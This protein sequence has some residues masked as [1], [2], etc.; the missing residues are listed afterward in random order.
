LLLYITLAP[1]DYTQI[2]FLILQLLFS[3]VLYIW[4]KFPISFT[5]YI[6]YQIC[7]FTYLHNIYKNSNSATPRVGVG[8]VDDLISRQWSRCHTWKSYCYH[9]HECTIWSAGTTL[10]CLLLQT[11]STA[12]LRYIAW[13]QQWV[14]PAS[15]HKCGGGDHKCGQPGQ[16]RGGSSTIAANIPYTTA[17]TA[18][19]HCKLS[20]LGLTKREEAGRKPVLTRKQVR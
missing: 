7:Y 19:V 8:V 14:T 3:A 10:I 4:Y 17:K 13:M 16:V 6:L 18:A 12:K 9:S 20:P 15:S 5:Y 11:C 2:N 1:A